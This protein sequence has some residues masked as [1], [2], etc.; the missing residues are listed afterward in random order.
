VEIALFKENESDLETLLKIL[1]DRGVRNV[2]YYAIA[3][4]HQS[5]G[6][7]GTQIIQAAVNVEELSRHSAV[8]YVWQAPVSARGE[9]RKLLAN[10]PRTAGD[11]S[12]RLEPDGSVYPARGEKIVAGNLLSMPFS[13]IWE[14]EVFRKYRERVET[15]TRCDICP[16][17]AICAA[18]CPADPRGWASE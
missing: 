1:Q 18:D 15:P 12:I 14:S 10:G 7:N 8:R 9:F 16:G 3:S 13:D 11:V 17:L 2:Q 4:T 6:L 5:S